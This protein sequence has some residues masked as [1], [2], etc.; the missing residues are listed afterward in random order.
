[1]D[2][3]GP[4]L[5][6]LQIDGQAKA[7]GWSSF[8]VWCSKCLQLM[9]GSVLVICRHKLIKPRKVVKCDWGESFVALL[10][11]FDLQQM[12]VVQVEISTNKRF[13]DPVHIVPITAPFRLTN[14]FKCFFVHLSLESGPQQAMDPQGGRNA[15]VVMVASRKIVI[16]PAHSRIVFRVAFNIEAQ[17]YSTYAFPPSGLLRWSR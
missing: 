13:D 12:S 4:K 5:P 3:V 16:Q 11:K 7:S 14:Q 1:M 15:D 17:Y 2:V 8:W 6:S 9:P 10:D